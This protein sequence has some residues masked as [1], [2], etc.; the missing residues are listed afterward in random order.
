M[1]DI[2]DYFDEP[3]K[4]TDAH[5]QAL[6][7]M[8]ADAALRDY[9]EQ[10]MRVANQNAMLMLEAQKLIEAQAYASRYKSIKQL[11]AKG[12]EY[13]IHFDKLRGIKEPLR[14]V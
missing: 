1:I 2:P 6:A 5:K 14:R 7:R 9:L 11:L 4:L 3:E 12:K 10:T 8:Y 13:F